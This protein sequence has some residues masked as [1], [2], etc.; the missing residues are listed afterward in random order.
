MAKIY[1]TYEEYLKSTNVNVFKLDTMLLQE[2][3]MKELASK[4]FIIELANGDKISLNFSENDFCHLIGFSHFGYDGG[5]GWSI[6]V[7]KPK[8]IKDFSKYKD[9]SIL[10]NRIKYFR[11]IV[12]VLMSPKVFLYKAENYPE[13]NYNANYFAVAYIDGRALKVGIAKNKNNDFYGETYLVDL[14]QEKYNYYLKEENLVEVISVRVVKKD[15]VKQE[16]AIEKEN[17]DK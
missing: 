10:L 14:D 15:I 2:F 6:L 16:V 11:N 17:N 12:D 8:N 4:V 13:F 1:N 5:Q 3:Y 7:N 9:F